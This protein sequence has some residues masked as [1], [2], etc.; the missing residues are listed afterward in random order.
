M[1]DT[2]QTNGEY[3]T[4]VQVRALPEDV[5]DWLGSTLDPGETVTALL[6]ADITASGDFG[7]RWAFLTNKRLMVFSPN[8]RE[9]EAD[10]AFEMSLEQIEDAEVREY[11]GS[12]T[13][14]VSSEEEGH[15]VA[16]FS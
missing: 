2:E 10:V 13:L 5:Q 1:S 14:I 8:G 9:G 3:G 16:R 7:E 15:E 12:S 11:V 4:S 6:L